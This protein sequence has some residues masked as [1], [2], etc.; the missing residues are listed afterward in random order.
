MNREETR[1]VVR[2]MDQ[3]ACD[4][5][6]VQRQ[7]RLWGQDEP[8][9][10]WI[11]DKCPSWDH[12]MYHYRIK[13]EPTIRP[14][15]MEECPVGEVVVSKEGA[16]KSLILDCGRGHVMVAGGIV[17]N[18]ISR[19]MAYRHMLDNYTMLNGDPCGIREEGDS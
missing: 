17:E 8:Q 11:D 10:D 5:V 12:A 18:R 2:V 15:T 13:P 19:D 3:W 16:R 9:G 14:W 6:E 7:V 1:E 4:G